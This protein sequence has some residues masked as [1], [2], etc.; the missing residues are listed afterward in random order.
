MYG[1]M[2]T[3]LLLFIGGCLD[4]DA[5]F[6]GHYQIDQTQKSAIREPR[7]LNVNKTR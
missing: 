2:R 3:G 4:K 1:D 6:T 7:S 5:Y